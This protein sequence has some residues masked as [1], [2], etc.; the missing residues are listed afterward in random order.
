MCNKNSFYTATELQVSKFSEKKRRVLLTWAGK[1]LC[2]PGFDRTSKSCWVGRDSRKG[3]PK[4]GSKPLRADSCGEAMALTFRVWT[5]GINQ[6]DSWI[7]H[8]R[9]KLVRNFFGVEE[10]RT[11]WACCL[12]FGVHLWFLTLPLALMSPLDMHRESCCHRAKDTSESW[13]YGPRSAGS[14]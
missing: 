5:A 2:K 8:R 3:A 14:R 4:W 6:D 13:R 7:K 9:T 11:V 10:R 1:Y 12:R